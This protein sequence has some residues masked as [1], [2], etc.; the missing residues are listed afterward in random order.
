MIQARASSASIVENTWISPGIRKR[1]ALTVSLT[2]DACS[3]LQ[4][5]QRSHDSLPLNGGETAGMGGK[6]PFAS[7]FLPK[8]IVEPHAAAQAATAQH[9][10][11][12]SSPIASCQP[13]SGAASR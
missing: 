4:F 12:A 2:A 10:D 5:D 6:P 11:M 13:N 1:I 8:L 3:A 9:G 7:A